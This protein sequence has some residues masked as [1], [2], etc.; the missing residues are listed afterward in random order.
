MSRMQVTLTS[1]DGTYSI[2]MR[3][4]EEKDTDESVARWVQPKRV[5]PGMKFKKLQTKI[6]RARGRTNY[7]QSTD[8]NRFNVLSL[9][10]IEL[11]CPL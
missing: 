7:K 11:N 4:V 2:T 6:Q 5:K 9:E 1:C 8:I 10:S 3:E